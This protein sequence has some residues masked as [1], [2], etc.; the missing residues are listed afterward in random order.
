[1]SNN[2]SIS[3][4]KIYLFHLTNRGVTINSHF[5]YVEYTHGCMNL[6]CEACTVLAQTS[7][8]ISG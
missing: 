3:A 6:I 7:N 4:I 2:D 5:K 1:M 8:K